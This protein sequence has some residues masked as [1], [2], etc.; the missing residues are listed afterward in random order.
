MASGSSQSASQPIIT[1]LIVRPLRCGVTLTTPQA[2]LPSSQGDWLVSPTSVPGALGAAR[3]AV[4]PPTWNSS[5]C[6]TPGTAAA[7]AAVVKAMA[8][9]RYMSASSADRQHEDRFCG[10]YAE[11]PLG[12][13]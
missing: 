9:L 3:N 7:S 11:L 12:V 1:C 10:R 6:A 8:V 13:F 5:A 4:V 2:A